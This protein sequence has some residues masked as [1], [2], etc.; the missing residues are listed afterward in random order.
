MLIVGPWLMASK[1]K[2]HREQVRAIV[3]SLSRFLRDNGLVTREILP[4]GAEITEDLVINK[5]DLTAEG[6]ALYHAAVE[7]KWLEAI[8]RGLDPSNTDILRKALV[9]IRSDQKSDKRSG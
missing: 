2:S 6:Y 5:S 9:A 4:E 3:R 1:R 7:K 8:D